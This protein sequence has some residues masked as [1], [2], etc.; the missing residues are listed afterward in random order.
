MQNVSNN[1]CDVGFTYIGNTNGHN[2]VLSQRA[3]TNKIILVA[4]NDEGTPDSLTPELMQNICLITLTVKNDINEIIFN[5]LENL[6]ISKNKLNC[7][8]RVEGIVGAKMM[9]SRGYG[10]TFLPYISVKEELYKKQ[11][12]I[13]S[14]PNLDIDLDIFLIYKNVHTEHVNDFLEWFKKNGEASFC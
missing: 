6:G 4:K 8:L 14:V 11:F 9:I 2:S 12:K 5:K 13:I 3:G 1:I 7:D 10:V